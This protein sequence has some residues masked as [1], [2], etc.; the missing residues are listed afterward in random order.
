MAQWLN[1]WDRDWTLE[2]L[3]LDE[4]PGLV[5]PYGD[6]GAA[7]LVIDLE[8]GFTVAHSWITDIIK[9][10]AGNEQRIARNDMDH[11]S[12]SGRAHLLRNA[13]RS[14]RALLAR[15]AAIGSLMLLGLPH[16]ELALRA[17]SSG[18]T[19]F[20]FA[21]AL[22]LTDWAKPTQ[23]VVVAHLDANGDL[24][25]IDAVIQSVGADSMVLS[26]APGDLGKYGGTIMPAKAIFLEP[27]QN[28]DRFQVGAETWQVA[29]RG[30]KPLDYA[31]DLASIPLSFLSAP[32]ANVVMVARRTGLA[33]N[34]ID[35]TFDGDAGYPATGVI[36]SESSLQTTF[37]FRPG[38]TTLQNLYDAFLL[39]TNFLMTGTF[40]GASTIGV[41]DEFLAS[42]S[43]GADSG[44][45]GNGAT[46]VTY[47]GDG[48][49][50]PVWDRE[51]NTPGTITDGVHAMTQ[52]IEHGGIPYALGIADEADWFRSVLLTNG[53]QE[54]WQWF[55]LFMATAKG[56]QKKFWL[57][58]WRDDMTFVS[59]SAN[60][61][62]VSTTDG[63]DFTAWWPQQR[64]H[65]QI[66]E[67]NGTVTRAKITAQIDNGNG[68]RTLTIGVTLATS[69][70]E[71]ISW[72]E[73]CRFEDADGY[74][75]THSGNGFSVALV[76]RVVP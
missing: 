61:I 55:K 20:V 10:R 7:T 74:Q 76:A 42:S 26:V 24:A 13:P 17:D 32:F 29:A 72:L 4:D 66:I 2:W 45:V 8:N 25:A 67:S 50:R 18:T 51:L 47:S 22:A 54:D 63:S 52:I 37:R 9:A 49:S 46:L 64:E 21:A 16:E 48:T 65:I 36:F 60:T 38:V 56:R 62:T 35:L 44:D 31:P 23:R 40:S 3:G 43:G 75:T 12:F 70:V 5:P 41:S 19:V 14:T 68:T 71:I 28:F 39:S 69:S 15:H 27:Q 59:K 30:A 53:D 6:A 1:E 58:T 73:L 57:P 33:G 34:D 11:Q